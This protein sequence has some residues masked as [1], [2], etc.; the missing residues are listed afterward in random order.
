MREFKAVLGFPTTTGTLDGSRLPVPPAKDSAVDYQNYKR[1]YGIILLA[2][3]DHRYLFRYIGMGFPD[4][5]HDANVY[6]AIFVGASAREL[7]MDWWHRDTTH[8]PVQ[9]GISSHQEPD[10]AFPPQFDHLQ[11]KSDY[12]YALSNV[13]HVVENAFRRL[14]GRFRIILKQIEVRIDNVIADVRACCTLH[15]ICET[16]NDSVGKQ[17]VKDVRKVEKD[18]KLEQLSHKTKAKMDSGTA[19]CAALVA[20]FEANPPTR[21][22]QASA[23]A[24]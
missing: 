20:Y 16:L 19:V 13:R 3:V 12:N 6:R 8:R 10:E 5:C 18:D 22:N 23:E 11:E 7:P 15:N 24:L 9:S 17:W 1:W 4:K 14:K 21:R 2:L